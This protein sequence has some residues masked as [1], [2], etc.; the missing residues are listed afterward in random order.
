MQIVKWKRSEVPPADILSA[1]K[2]IPLRDAHMS[3]FL[4]EKW[5]PAEKYLE[6]AR[7]GLQIKDDMGLDIAVCFAKRSVCRRVDSLILKNHLRSCLHK[8]YPEKI[9]ALCDIGIPIPDIVQ[10]WIIGPRNQLEHK[11]ETVR[12]NNGQGAIEIA[13]LFI[14]ATDEEEKRG[15]I[16]AVGWNVLGGMQFGSDTEMVVQFREFHS[17]PML[18]LDIFEE[19]EKAKIVIPLEGEIILAPMSEFSILEEIELANLLRQHYSLPGRSERKIPVHFYL[20]IK[21]Q[22]QF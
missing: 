7:R 14:R 9:K 6:W 11:Y 22:G 4:D 1:A 15:C 8:K 3:H 20:E 21:R 5:L 2:T 16:F 13:D 19:P 12:N 17:N 18:F 10:S